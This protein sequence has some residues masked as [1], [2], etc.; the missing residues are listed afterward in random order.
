MSLYSNS[1]CLLQNKA[2]VEENSVSTARLTHVFDGGKT[3][4]HI[5]QHQVRFSRCGF[6]CIEFLAEMVRGIRIAWQQSMILL[7]PI[8]DK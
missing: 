5:Q 3:K 2:C 7:F 4:T 8:F 1:L 6:R